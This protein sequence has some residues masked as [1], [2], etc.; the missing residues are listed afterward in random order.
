MI[1]D[2]IERML[3]EMLTEEG[4]R[5]ELRRNELAERLGCVPSQIN[6]VITSRFTPERGY[7][8]ESRRGGGGYVRIT[9]KMIH[10]DEYLMHLFCAIGD[11]IDIKSAA[12]Y[13]AEMLERGLITEREGKM[14]AAMLSVFSSDSERALALKKAILAF[15]K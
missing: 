2:V 6:Y 11:E 13:V 7:I 9:K 1:S 15:S 8:I 14:T 3:I 10:S 5:L 4:G 12:L